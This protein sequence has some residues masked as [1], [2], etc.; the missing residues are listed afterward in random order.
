MNIEQLRSIF[1]MDGMLI[2][3]CIESGSSGSVYQIQYI[4]PLAERENQVLKVIDIAE[5]AKKHADASN[6]ERV[7]KTALLENYQRELKLNEKITACRSEYLV[8][9]LE[10]YLIKR[11]SEGI[12]LCA[13]RMPYYDTLKA[14]C[15]SSQLDEKTVI[16]VGMH[17]CEALSILHHDVKDEYYRR[18]DAAFGVMLHMDVKPSNIF[19]RK[20]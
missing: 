5:M 14:L 15:A 16:R 10:P 2:E 8:R 1:F 7:V 9:I 3:K 4:D 13:I 6:P 11:E 17:V 19:Y 12:C 18:Q 20:E